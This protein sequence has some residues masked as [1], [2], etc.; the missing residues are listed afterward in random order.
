MVVF[1]CPQVAWQFQRVPAVKPIDYRLDDRHFW[2][3]KIFKSQPQHLKTYKSRTADSDFWSWL[4]HQLLGQ[5]KSTIPNLQIYLPK[6]ANSEKLGLG[7]DNLCRIVFLSL[8]MNK[9]LEMVNDWH[10]S[11]PG[12]VSYAM[13]PR[14]HPYS[15]VFFS[16]SY[17]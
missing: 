10:F 6:K 14:C 13:I 5:L 11:N 9:C 16:S 4:T 12:A 7:I 3:S 2:L 8:R 15:R 1:R 17:P